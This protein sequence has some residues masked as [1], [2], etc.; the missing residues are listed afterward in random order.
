MRQHKLLWQSSYDRGLNVLL[1]L[2]PEILA[3]YPNAELHIAY[4]WELFDIVTK[5]NAERQEWKATMVELMKQKGIKVHGRLGKTELKK[6]RKECGILAYCSD[7][8]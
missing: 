6:L 5:T 4:G 3:K 1:K 7:F 8:R 2:W